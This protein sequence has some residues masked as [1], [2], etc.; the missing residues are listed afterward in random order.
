MFQTY[1]ELKRRPFA[2]VPSP[3]QYF[4]AASI[5]A[6][7]VA[8]VRMVER[9]EGTGLVIGAVGVGKSLLCRMIA[10]SFRQ[11]SRVVVLPGGRLNTR[12]SL[13]Q[14]IL[15]ELGLP[16]RD[17]EE[18][19]L[20]LALID[21]L[22]N[23]DLCPRGM[24]LLVD[25]AENLPLALLD[26]LRTLTNLTEAG[27][28][29]VRLL[30]F[31]NARLEEK[32]THP[33]LESLNQRLAGR[34]YLEPF[35]YEETRQYIEHQIKR[36]G[37]VPGDILDAAAY[38]AIHHATGGI[39]RLINQLADHALVLAA[40]GH[41]PM[42]NAKCVDE[43]WADLQQLPSPSAQ[44]SPDHLPDLPADIIEFGELDDDATDDI[45]ETLRSSL[46]QLERHMDLAQDELLDESNDY[47]QDSTSPHT[48]L[49]LADGTN[50]VTLVFHPTHDPFGD[51]FDEEETV[52]DE[53]V[54]PDALSQRHRRMVTCTESQAIA[55]SL[56]RIGHS[57]TNSYRPPTDE[58][59]STA[60]LAAHTPKLRTVEELD[61]QDASEANESVELD[62]LPLGPIN[63]TP[64]TMR[65][66]APESGE[67]GDWRETGR[68]YG[69]VD[70]YEH[71]HGH[72]RAGADETGYAEGREGEYREESDGEL[73][74]V[75]Q[76]GAIGDTTQSNSID[77]YDFGVELFQQPLEVRTPTWNQD[78]DSSQW[79]GSGELLANAA[80]PEEDLVDT[81]NATD[82]DEPP[83]I[84]DLAQS[85]ATPS[86]NN[87][88]DTTHLKCEQIECNQ[89]E[90]EP[91]EVQL[92]QCESVE[93]VELVESVE[94]VES[95][96]NDRMPSTLV[97]QPLEPNEP[98]RAAVKTTP[99][100][101]S[102]SRLGTTA[103]IKP[104]PANPTDRQTEPGQAE[105][106]G[107]TP[108]ST[109]GTP[110]R[111]YRRLFSRLRDS[112]R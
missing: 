108:P 107:T 13:L 91:S 77:L 45:G 51:G 109:A 43:A 12:R 20:R 5:E 79:P 6:S 19:E 11:L 49:S 10:E 32:F 112:R 69:Y 21:Y 86:E 83:T 66:T 56:D 64:E 67:D 97:T 2:S 62:T 104:V 68:E 101:E 60:P 40:T 102:D 84:T 53:F 75:V 41:F 100:P 48:A 92:S 28:A 55:A 71:E 47:D 25:E 94:S 61:E 50:E 9:S 58:L 81:P 105:R 95:V 110:P 72:E 26:E 89:I 4:P 36:S 76:S 54:S 78:L 31:G 93:L 106:T 39:P 7:R 74:L 88:C 37:N 24:V 85:R 30:L 103:A 80:I 46:E 33:R 14:V 96:A 22:T 1:F 15:Y 17:M 73:P 99:L 65:E 90:S 23:V 16:Y 42:I 18:G 59:N 34:F 111:D 8:L 29:C 57:I 35:K 52:I 44:Q 98:M 63:S 82:S 38:R 87:S 70:G 27:R 3:E